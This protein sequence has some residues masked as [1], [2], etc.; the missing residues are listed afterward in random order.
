[1]DVV[2]R[3]LVH[4]VGLSLAARRGS[5]RRRR[6]QLALQDRGAIVKGGVADLVVL[7]ELVTQTYG[8]RRHR[9]SDSRSEV[10]VQKRAVDR[11]F[12]D[13]NRLPKQ[14]PTDGADSIPE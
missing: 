7:D 9:R 13:G 12:A 8:S 4:H 1:M 5:A 6:R 2:F 14:G 11:E 10:R 3:F